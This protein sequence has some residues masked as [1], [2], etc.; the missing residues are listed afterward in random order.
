MPHELLFY[1]PF[2][3]GAKEAAIK[4][5][6]NALSLFCFLCVSLVEKNPAKTAFWRS[7]DF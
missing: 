2:N 3:L 5:A 4:D 6:E 1:S 7:F